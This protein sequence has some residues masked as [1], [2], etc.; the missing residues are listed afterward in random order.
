M[1]CYGKSNSGVNKSMGYVD[2]DIVV[3]LDKKKS[4]ISYFFYV[5][6]LC[7]KLE[8]IFVASGGIIF[9]WSW[10]CYNYKDN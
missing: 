6:Q 7:D 1:V 5:E 8:S 9:N 3:D 10:I 4:I 2:F